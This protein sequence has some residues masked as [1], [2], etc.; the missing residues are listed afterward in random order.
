MRSKAI[1]RVGYVGSELVEFEKITL[2]E[3]ARSIV[4]GKDGAFYVS[5]DNGEIIKFS[6]K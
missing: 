4:N 2:G 1:H 5:T 3:R 6:P